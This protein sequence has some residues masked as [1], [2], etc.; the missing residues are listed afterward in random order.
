MGKE[1]GIWPPGLSSITDISTIPRAI[2]V[3]SNFFSCMLEKRLQQWLIN[4]QE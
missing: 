1:G 2:Q 3:A 4:K